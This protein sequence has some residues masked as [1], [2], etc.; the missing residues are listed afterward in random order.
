MRI[1]LSYLNWPYSE[2]DP[3]GVALKSAAGSVAS[4][5]QKMLQVS[6]SGVFITITRCFDVDVPLADRNILLAYDLVVYVTAK[7]GIG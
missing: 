3:I 5:L 2:S 7:N 1:K 6:R 4:L